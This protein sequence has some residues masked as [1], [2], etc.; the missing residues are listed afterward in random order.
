[1]DLKKLKVSKWLST[2]NMLEKHVIY[3]LKLAINPF[4]R[5]FV[6]YNSAWKLGSA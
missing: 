1:M 6:V 4:G 3:N 2:K 5:S